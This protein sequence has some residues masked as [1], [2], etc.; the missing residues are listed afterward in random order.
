MNFNRT[1]EA[2]RNRLAAMVDD[3]AADAGS[4]ASR[5]ADPY[6][7]RRQLREACSI[8]LDRIIPDPDQPRKEFDPDALGRLAESLRARGQ[9]QPI[10]VRWDE[11][12]GVTSS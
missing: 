7:G 1:E 8:R 9:L 11:G 5:G 2:R 4:I 6:E 10:R 12:R 3:D